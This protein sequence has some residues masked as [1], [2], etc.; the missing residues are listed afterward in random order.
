MQQVDGLLHFGPLP[1]IPLLL[2]PCHSKWVAATVPAL[3]LFSLP[4]LVATI[5]WVAAT[6]LSEDRSWRSSGL[7]TWSQRTSATRTESRWSQRGRYASWE[8]PQENNQVKY[9]VYCFVD[10]N[11]NNN[12]HLKSTPNFIKPKMEIL[13]AQLIV[14]PAATEQRQID[15]ALSPKC[16]TP[17]K[18]AANSRLLTSLTS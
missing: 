1:Y 17:N 12:N 6:V 4:S 9:P 18:V 7:S 15:V 16:W 3:I 14:S 10:N 8:V 5:Q 11:N 2:S 13:F